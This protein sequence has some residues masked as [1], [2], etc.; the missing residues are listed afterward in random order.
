MI[1]YSLICS[2]EH[3][4]DGWF[5]SSADYDAQADH[6]LLSCPVCGS[7]EVD[8]ALMAPAVPARKQQAP[9][10][11]MMLIGDRETEIRGMIRKLREEVTRNAEDVGPRFAEVARQMHEGEVEKN[12]VYGV[13]TPDE[14]RSLRDDGIEFHPLPRLPDDGN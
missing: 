13:A 9:S 3:A 4:F 14:V 1:R 10:E 7:P 12:S 2:A 6:G 5:R 11:Q 8:K